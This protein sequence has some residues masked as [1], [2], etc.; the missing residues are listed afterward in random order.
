MLWATIV[1][2]VIGVLTGA[3]ARLFYPDRLPGHILGTMLLGAIGALVAGMLSWIYWPAEEN[4]IQFASLLLSLSGA[5]LVIAFAA[6]R[7]YARRVSS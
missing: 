1:F 2:V 6:G 3:S 5:A 4:H 7:N